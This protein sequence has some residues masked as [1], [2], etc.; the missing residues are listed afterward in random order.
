M[1]VK[2]FDI[3]GLKLFRPKIFGDER[4]YFYESFNQAEYDE[5]IG[6]E[7]FVQDNVSKSKKVYCGVCIF[8]TSILRAN[9][10]VLC[11]V[12]YMM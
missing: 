9:L 1:K 12:V 8:R 10:F 5:H 2:S 3:E 4:G 11:Q 6:Y 7:V